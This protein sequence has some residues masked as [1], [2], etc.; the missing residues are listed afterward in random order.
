M[1]NY[2]DPMEKSRI[3]N[4]LH[5]IKEKFSELSD[6]F[7]EDSKE[8]ARDTMKNMKKKSEEAFVI[9]KKYGR[10]HPFTIV[11]L[12]IATGIALTLL[13]RRSK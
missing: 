7:M 3:S 1:S 12:G 5:E 13:F 9:S 6:Q 11:A 4:K 10:N 2:L 8:M